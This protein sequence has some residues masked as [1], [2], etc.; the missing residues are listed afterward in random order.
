MIDVCVVGAG[1]AGLA[2]AIQSAKRGARTLLLERNAQA[3][4]KLLAT[5]GGHCN[6]G[7]LLPEEEWPERFG[8]RGRFIV[9]ALRRLPTAR[10]REWFRELGQPLA[11]GD[12]FH[13]FPES[14][15]A[16]GVRDALLAQALRLG[17]EVRYGCRAEST[18]DIAAGSIIL[19]TGGRS[20][21]ATGSTWDGCRMAERL[22]HAITPARPGL[23]G[24][25]AANLDAGLAGVVLPRARVVFRKKGRAGEIGVGELL[26]THGGVSGPAVLDLSASASPEPGKESVIFITWHDGMDKPAWTA[27][28]AAWRKKAGGTAIATLLRERFPSR[29]ARWLCAHA[30][31]AGATPAELTAAGRENLAGALGAFPCRVTASEGWEKA[32]ITR[33]GVDV[34]QVEPETLGSRLVPSLY[35]A[36][37]MLDI[38]GPC[39]GYNLHW[40]FAS[41]V[42]AGESAAAFHAEGEQACCDHVPP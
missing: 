25:R 26:L 35:F 33:G 41:G 17:V 21:P 38:D 10:L 42:L 16:R 27:Q 24:L 37:E 9:P 8:R 23:V 3:G 18:E 29:L 36:G 12:G 13:L 7:N 20:Y 28:L 19:A 40:A 22:G 31:A 11:C 39:G 1:P 4:V 32:M 5:G 15:S 14:R 30:G 34:R 2:A 6:A